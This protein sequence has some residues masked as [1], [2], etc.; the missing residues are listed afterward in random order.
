MSGGPGVIR[1]PAGERL[2]HTFTPA[3][4]HSA[5]SVPET[6]VI[7]AHGVTAHKD[8]PWLV[9]LSAAMSEAGVASLRLSFAGNGAS[10]GRFEESNPSKEVGDLRS[11]IDVLDRWGVGRIAYVGHSMGGAVGVLT[12]AEEPRIRAL[13]SL[14]GMV[15]VRWFFETHFAHLAPGAPMLEKP[16][17][18]W[19]LALLDDARR[20]DT[21]L[22]QAAQIEVPWLLV[23]GDA[24]ELVPYQDSVDAVAAAGGRPTLVTMTGID[25]RF[26]GVVPEMVEAV[27]AWLRHRF[28]SAGPDRSAAL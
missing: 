18:P 28:A 27:V 9:A 26:T 1:N 24:D 10:E 22:P 3:E 12:A 19:S 13:V 25:H 17:C 11:V 8:R 16:E 5:D 15:R 20:V 23:H 21:V 2:D 6:V 14:A 4:G 7:L